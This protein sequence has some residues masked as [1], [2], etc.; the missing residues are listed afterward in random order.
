MR[1]LTPLFI[2]SLIVVKL[3]LASMFLYQC[4]LEAFF[5]G[6]SAIASEPVQSPEERPKKGQMITHDDFNE[7]KT[8]LKRKAELQEQEQ[9]IENK[10]AEL[11]AIQEDITR[12]ISELSKL[13]EEIRADISEKKSLEEEAVSKKKAFEAQKMKHLIKAYASMKP[14]VAANLVEKLDTGFAV[15]LLSRMKGDVVGNILSFVD[16]EKAA[17]ISEGLVKLD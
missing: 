15:E 7:L 5:F 4:D 2:A 1:R 8:I 16:I 11:I 9:A 14:Q 13:R 3:L 12:K 6:T 17:K 10:K